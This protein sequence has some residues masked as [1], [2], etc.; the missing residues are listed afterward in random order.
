LAQLLGAFQLLLRQTHLQLALQPIEQ[1]FYDRLFSPAVSLWYLLFQRLHPDH[2]LQAAVCDAHAGG[3][4]ALGR[5]ERRP[6]SQRIR[7]RATTAFSNARQRLPLAAL[8]CALSGQAQVIWESV[9]DACWRGWRV[10]L[11]DGSQV[12]LRP[13][14]DLL[15][16]FRPSSNQRGKAYWILM[17]V[18]AGFCVQTA[19]VVG[20]TI[21]SPQLSE[22]ALAGQL[23]A[24]TIGS[25]LYIGDSN[26]GIFSVAAAILQANQQCLFRLTKDRAAKLLGARARRAGCLDELVRWSPSARDRRRHKAKDPLLP[27]QVRV[28]MLR[29]LR[30]GFRPQQLYLVTTLMDR[31]TYPAAEL[32]ELYGTRWQVELDLRYLKAQMDLN[33]LECKTADMAQKEWLAGLMAYNLVRSLMLNTALQKNIPCSKLSFS[34]TRRLLLGWLTDWSKSADTAE[35]WTE[36]LQAVS[37][38]AQPGRTNPRPNEP[39]LKRH[40]RESFPPLRGSRAAARKKLQNC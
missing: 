4:D 12:R 38:L 22:Q 3:A 13:S 8:P 40:V 2:S 28:L 10:L 36:L 14:A 29:M 5:P 33:F 31:N 18:V 26:F 35:S 19:T 21:G 1:T 37:E 9:Q 23:I 11:L 27:I 30:P 16:H 17:R 34:A 6:L 32:M 15:A 24:K 25:A 20:S 39:R 7:S